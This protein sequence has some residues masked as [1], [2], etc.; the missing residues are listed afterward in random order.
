MEFL[1]V[2]TVSPNFV[3]TEEFARS[4][5]HPDVQVVSAFVAGIRIL[6]LTAQI[7]G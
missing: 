2:R 3:P 4:L 1:G 7:P 5:G 6:K